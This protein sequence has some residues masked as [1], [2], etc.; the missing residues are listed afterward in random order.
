MSPQ[1]QSFRF[2]TYRLQDRVQ[3]ESTIEFHTL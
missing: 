3:N 1:P 2:V